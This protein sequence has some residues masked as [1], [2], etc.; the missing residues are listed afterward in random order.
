M[1]DENGETVETKG[2]INNKAI[3]NGEES[4]EVKTSIIKSKKTSAIL[5]D[6][7]QV[8]K[9]KIGDTII[10]YISVENSNK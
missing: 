10:Y 8:E 9:A 3:A 4:N 2:I 1:V 7:E 5:R 6:K